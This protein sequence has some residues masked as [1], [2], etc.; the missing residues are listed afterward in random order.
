MF[1]GNGVDHSGGI[2]VIN[3]DQV[4]TQQLSPRPEGASFRRRLRDHERRAGLAAQ[5]LFP[6]RQRPDREQFDHRQPPHRTCGGQ[7]RRAFGNTGQQRFQGKPDL[8]TKTGAILSPSTTTSAA[9]PS[10]GTRS[11]DVDDTPLGE[12]FANSGFELRQGRQWTT[13]SRWMKRWPMRSVFPQDLQVLERIKYRCALVP[14]T[15]PGQSLRFRRYD[16]NRTRPRFACR[17]RPPERGCRRYHRPWRRA[18]TW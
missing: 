12:G 15:R 14:Q 18:N 9:S 3:F 13:V 7:R 10:A 6:G 4:G 11:T 8:T 2:R 5:P 1:L 17:M 16:R